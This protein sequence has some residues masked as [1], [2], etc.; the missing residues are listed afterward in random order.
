MLISWCERFRWII[1]F[2]WSLLLIITLSLIGSYIE[3]ITTS[4]STPG[5]ASS[6][7]LSIYLHTRKPTAKFDIVDDDS[8]SVFF[9]ELNN[10]LHNLTN[11]ISSTYWYHSTI[12][13]GLSMLS[14]YF[15]SSD[16]NAMIFLA[17]F[18][19]FSPSKSFYSDLEQF[20]LTHPVSTDY[21]VH[22]LDENQLFTDF[23]QAII[24]DVMKV[25]LLVLPLCVLVL[26]LFMKCLL[27]VVAPIIV[28]TISLTMTL[29]FSYFI[30]VHY[31]IS[32]Y[33]LIFQVAHLLSFSLSLN[34]SLIIM[35]RLSESATDL[36]S[37]LSHA[38]YN[39]G[40]TISV[41]S[42]TLFA[43]LLALAVL[44]GQQLRGMAMSCIVVLVFVL[45]ACFTFLPC[46]FF[47]FHR[48]LPSNG[49]SINFHSWSKCPFIEKLTTILVSKNWISVTAVA[50]IAALFIPS[51]INLRNLELTVDVSEVFPSNVESSVAIQSMSDQ[52][53]PGL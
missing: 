29:G 35:S 44:G 15:V 39:G 23:L 24:S 38:F 48:F 14:Q 43:S 33:V 26:I 30:S 50:C 3:N 49:E 22:I 42:S 20:V 8:V 1:L 46:F 53:L 28:I 47:T 19:D 2:Y 45:M 18:S 34:Y 4:S 51:V 13:R 41:S 37:S 11:Q 25:I 31:P 6:S 40:V 5:L 12:E 32:A 9:D 16:N 52:F 27:F 10:Q 7:V 17:L 21:N 36:H